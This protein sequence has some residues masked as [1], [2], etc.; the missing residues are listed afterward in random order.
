[1]T[2]NQP[3]LGVSQLQKTCPGSDKPAVTDAMWGRLWADGTWVG[4]SLQAGMLLLAGMLVFG[5]GFRRAQLQ[6]SLGS[7]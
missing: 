7:Y 3:F 2:T 4:L 6:G 1:M 5:W